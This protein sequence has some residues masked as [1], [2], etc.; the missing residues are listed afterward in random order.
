MGRGRALGA[1]GPR[2]DRARPGQ[3][4]LGCTAG[5]NPAAHTTTDR[6]PNAKRNT[7]RDKTNARLNTTSDKRNMIRHD[8]TPMI[9]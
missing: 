2:L 6:K 8:A 1:R 5:Q 7:Q 9:T 4:G 3:P